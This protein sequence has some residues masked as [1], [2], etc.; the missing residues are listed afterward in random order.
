[1]KRVKT[2]LK[3]L[4]GFCTF[5]LT[6]QN[7]EFRQNYTHR[8]FLNPAL[9]G[10]GN[11]DNQQAT[12]LISGFKAK[13]VGL[14]RRLNS[15]YLNSDF[16]YNKNTSFGF[17]LDATEFISSQKLDRAY[18]FKHFHS[19]L[20]YAY[21]INT[22]AMNMKFGLSF[23]ISNFSFGS[24]NFIWGDQINQDMT[25]F[26]NPTKEPIENL[27]QT[28]LYSSVGCFLFKRDWFFGAATF[29][30]NQ[31]DISFYGSSS[32]PIYRK[33]VIHGGYQFER[34]FSNLIFT[35]TFYFTSQNKTNQ[36]GVDATFNRGNL[37]YGSGYRE[38]RQQQ[39]SAKSLHA[40]LNLRQ[41]K[42]VF[43]YDLDL[44]ISMS[45]A[46]LPLTHEFFLLYLIRSKKQQK[47]IYQ[48]P[49]L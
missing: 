29:N 6:A 2:I 33:Y 48:L 36:F 37:F 17:N 34:K 41:A 4:I 30:V 38:F 32:Q 20:T 22:D 47:A 46:Y 5:H 42:W 13:W 14:N 21:L 39:N 31:P 44:N 27:N 28:A 25:A 7:V 8:S 19:S 12:R 3:M 11:Y 40:F 9:I 35:P 16:S 49:T 1:M 45:N 10:L 43:G 15:T 24:A 26:S 23:D 18:S